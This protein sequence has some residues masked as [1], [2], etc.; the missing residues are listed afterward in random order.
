ME[1][2]DF[3]KIWLAK[4]ESEDQ[5]KFIIKEVS[6]GLFFVAALLLVVSI[7]LKN[8]GFLDAIIFS[9]LALLLLKLKSRV[10]AI[11]CLIFSSFSLVVTFSNSI[12]QSKSGGNNVLLALIVVW[13]SIRAI[14][15]TLVLRKRSAHFIWYLIAGIAGVIVLGSVLFLQKNNLSDSL[16]VF[17]SNKN[18]KIPEG[19]KSYKNQYMELSA[20]AYPA[21][22]T[23]SEDRDK[24]QVVFESSDKRNAVTVTLLALDKGQTL[25]YSTYTSALLEKMKGNSGIQFYKVS[26]EIRKINDK[27]WLVFD[28]VLHLNGNSV[29][30]NRYALC[31]TGKFSG[32]QYIQ[33][34]LES[35][36]SHFLADAIVFDKII[37]SAKFQ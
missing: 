14:Q 24:Y 22:W 2:K 4:I 11:F 3:K 23:V 18:Y 7:L 31:V 8:N 20:L 21:D 5:A 15:A 16:T 37:E 35:D 17:N 30:Y 10:A 26:E 36:K 9:V 13:G 1:K 28:G 19:F 6:Y 12:S 33:F 34:I 27:D 29:Y 25:D 32:R